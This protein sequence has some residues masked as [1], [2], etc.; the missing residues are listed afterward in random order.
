L[1]GAL[2][3]ANGDPKEVARAYGITEVEMDAALAYY[4]R[5]REYI[6]AV[7]LLNRDAFEAPVP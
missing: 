1:I 2:P 4:H 7:L 6:D 5:H 3:S